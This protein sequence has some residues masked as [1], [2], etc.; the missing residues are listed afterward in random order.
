MIINKMANAYTNILSLTLSNGLYLYLGQFTNT[1]VNFDPTVIGA[2]TITTPISPNNF[3]VTAIEGRLYGSNITG[4]VTIS[5]G[6]TGPNYDDIIL[7]T[8]L[9]GVN[10][11]GD[12]FRLPVSGKYA[13][14]TSGTPIRVYVSVAGVGSGAQIEVNVE[15]K[16]T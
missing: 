15:G 9:T 4:T 11:I 14:A 7:A 1:P 13:L 8:P 2:T 5:L 3:Q 6:V 16:I 10:T 12:R